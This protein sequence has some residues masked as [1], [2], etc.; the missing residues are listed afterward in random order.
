M[1]RARRVSLSETLDRVLHKGAVLTGDLVISVADVELV[2][3]SI[4]ALVASVDTV[5]DWV[6]HS[7]ENEVAP[8]LGTAPPLGA[9]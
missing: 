4:N 6:E 8:S 3:I 9:P 5:R 2:Y 7:R 1:S